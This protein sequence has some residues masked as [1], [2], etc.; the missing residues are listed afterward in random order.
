M[1]QQAETIRAMIRHENELAN[2][3][4]SWLNG[5]QGLLFTAMAFAWKDVPAH[6]RLMTLLAGIGIV[7]ALLSLVSLGMSTFAITRLLRWWE[8]NKGS[9]SG[10]PVV[11]AFVNPESLFAYLA[12][13]NILPLVFLVAWIFVLV[14][15][16]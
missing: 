1:E 15:H 6:P 7:V 5:V 9:Y 13:W 10:A 14:I 3:R 2:H 16:G 4:A 11:G 8:A 12:P